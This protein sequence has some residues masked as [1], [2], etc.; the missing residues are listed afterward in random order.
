MEEM[1]LPNFNQGVGRQAEMMFDSALAAD[2]NVAAKDVNEWKGV[3]WTKTNENLDRIYIHKDGTAY[4]CEMKNTLP[5][6]ELA[7]FESKLEMCLFLKLRPLFIVRMMPEIY[8]QRVWRKGGYSLVYKNQFYPFGF[9]DLAERVR[10]RLELP[11]VCARAV[12]DGDITRFTNWHAKTRGPADSE[13]NPREGH[14]S[15]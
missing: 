9:E 12:P 11:V 7:E 14:V 10:R 3:K 5:Y 2:F 8:I 15:D 4:G 1:S 13:R 6:I